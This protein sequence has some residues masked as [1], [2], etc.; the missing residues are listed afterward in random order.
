[1][2]ER[3]EVKVGDYV[4]SGFVCQGIT[5]SSNQHYRIVKI[6]GGGDGTILVKV[7]DEGDPIL[8]IKRYMDSPSPS[9]SYLLPGYGWEVYS[10]DQNLKEI[11]K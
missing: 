9:C 4:K 7:R 3:V 2:K 1:M 11:L 8:H 5:L 6:F 10:F